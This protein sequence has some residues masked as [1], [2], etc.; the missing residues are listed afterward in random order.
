MARK[1]SQSLRK[2]SKRVRRRG[3]NTRRRIV[4]GSSCNI[5][6][7]AVIETWIE[8]ELKLPKT[9]RSYR[10]TLVNIQAYIDTWR[11]NYNWREMNFA[12]GNC[13]NGNIPLQQLLSYADRKSREGKDTKQNIMKTFLDDSGGMMTTEM[14]KNR[15]IFKTE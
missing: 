10:T 2:K 7:T 13:S 8:K 4:G 5:D 1:T 9:D 12:I 14:G 11:G 15:D 3:R 6:D